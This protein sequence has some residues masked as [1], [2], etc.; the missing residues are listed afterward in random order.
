MYGGRW[1][2]RVDK[3]LPTQLGVHEDM[4]RQP[5]FENTFKKRIL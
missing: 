4:G 3:G 5:E 2:S 1:K